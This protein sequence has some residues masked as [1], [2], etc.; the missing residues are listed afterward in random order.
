MA[1]RRL[2]TI[3]LLALSAA[4]VLVGVLA[5]ASAASKTASKPSITRV[6][7]MRVSVG[8]L[9]TIRGRHFKA[10]RTANTVI[11]RGPSGRA[12]FAKPRRASREKLVVVV[13]GAASRLL[14]VA[15]S[16]QRPTR[17]KLRVLAGKFS[18]YTP[19]RLSPV[20]TSIGSGDGRRPS[21]GGGFAGGGSGSGVGGG[22]VVAVCADD[23]DLLSRDREAQ[24]KTDPCLADTDRD[25]VEDGFEQL[26][27]ERLNRW[28]DADTIPYPGKRPFPNALDPS[29]AAHDY[30]GDGLTLSD[31]FRL[32][33]YGGKKPVLDYNDGDQRTVDQPAP[34]SPA[35]VAWAID[36]NSDG[37]LSD[38]E[39]DADA[40]G[41]TNWDEAHG[42]MTPAWWV[43]K[44][45]G[46]NGPKETKYSGVEYPA[47]E[48][49]DPDS[50]GDG[51]PDGADDQDRDGLSNAFEVRRPLDWQATYVSTT[52]DGMPSP[53]PW[54]RVH[55]FNPCKPLWS[56]RCHL[57]PPFGAY[58]QSE[59]WDSPWGF[60]PA[61]FEWSP[62][63]PPEINPDTPPATP[64]G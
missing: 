50:D 40:D 54:A 62:A 11:F 26:S 56:A 33:R 18:R 3:C 22:N 1:M 15:G 34:T 30:D 4:V 9:L 6:T 32:W 23:N 60:Y 39:R 52:H 42:R 31:E 16:R 37:K 36:M 59:D 48:M 8:S 44:Y 13:P 41:L 7:P 10:K 2:F 43:S 53:N 51:L 25:G 20:V 49:D 55:P 14:T 12:T 64:A 27:A 63:L 58:P 29:D 24:I 45:D 5:S 35:L 17:L 21:G 28:S 46:T 57:H 19:R 61:D 47:T 38:D